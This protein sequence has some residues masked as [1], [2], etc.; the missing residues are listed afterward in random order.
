[1]WL[2]QAV[3]RVLP[4]HLLDQE[5]RSYDTCWGTAKRDEPCPTRRK[6]DMKL[7]KRIE[8]LEASLSAVIGIAAW[9]DGIL[10]E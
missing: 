3:T 7:T 2:S 1:M 8:D 9:A 10:N 5:N 6:K 4:D